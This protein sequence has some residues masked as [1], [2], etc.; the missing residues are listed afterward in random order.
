MTK[1]KVAILGGGIAG[2]SAAHELVERGFEVEVFD[3][4]RLYAGGKARSVNVPATNT[5]DPHKYLPGEHG[6]RFFPGFYKHVTDTMK[7]IPF[8]GQKEGVYDNLVAVTRAGILRNGQNPIYTLV[9]FPKSFDDLRVMMQTLHAHTGLTG[10]EEKFFAGKLW[11][12]AT[13]CYERRVNEYEKIGWWQYL[14]ADRFS[15]TYQ[16]LLVQGITRT[17]VAANAKKASTKTGGDIFLQLLFNMTDPGVNTDRVLNGPTNDAWI[18]P[19]LDYLRSKGVIYNFSKSAKKIEMADGRV[20]GVWVEAYTDGVPKSDLVTADYYIFATPVEV[21]ADLISD[22]VLRADPTLQGIKT[23][24]PSVAWM[25]GIQF[26]LSA[27]IDV[28]HGHCIYSDS[29]WAITSISQL[30][31]WK[32]YDITARYDGKVQTILSVD[33]SDW[34]EPGILE[35]TGKKPA[36]DCSYEEIKNEVWAQMKDS[37]NVN[38]NIVLRDE[39]LV[40]WYIDHDITVSHQREDKDKEPLLVNTINS[41]DLRPQAYTHIPNLFLASDY[42]QTYTDLATME[43]ANEAARR[44]VN[45]IIE[46]SGIKAALCEIWNLHEPGFLAGMRDTD[47]KRYAEGLPYQFY[48]P[49]TFRLLETTVRVFKRLFGVSDQEGKTTGDAR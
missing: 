32:D 1:T 13:T 29:P 30:Q 47:Q 17:L 49:L 35:A 45:A 9:N 27:T 8:N 10:E 38:E 26:Y 12:L 28:V 19:W 36:R 5:P 44:A 4:H 46:A 43:G 20:A 18:N 14:E 39:D 21:M 41:W 25:N 31:F 23:L 22:D 34:D 7:R 3:K 24:A 11:Q 6:F 16:A 33:I 42:V 37:L 48:E 15:K 2:M 40:H